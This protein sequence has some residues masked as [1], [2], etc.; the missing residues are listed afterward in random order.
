VV[1][2]VAGDVGRLT[3]ARAREIA[4]RL[5]AGAFVLGDDVEA[6]NQAGISPSFDALHADHPVAGVAAVHGDAAD[7]FTAVE[8]LAR[9][10]LAI[11]TPG[12]TAPL[13][14]R[15]LL[16]TRSAEA[17]QAYVEG[18]REYRVGRYAAAVAAFQRAITADTGFTLAYLRLSQ[19]ANWT[20]AV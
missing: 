2:A 5:G 9:R 1:D 20:G 13:T 17:L 16:A 7:L 3:A 6:Q 15:L 10:L 18:E 8:E 11:R 19:A 14:E 12:T 4:R